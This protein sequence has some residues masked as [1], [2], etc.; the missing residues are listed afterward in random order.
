MRHGIYFSA[1][2]VAINQIFQFLY[3]YREP[4]IIYYFLQ[5]K[6]KLD[7]SYIFIFQYTVFDE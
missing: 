2:F 3:F 7:L 5:E 1:E 6:S 4:I